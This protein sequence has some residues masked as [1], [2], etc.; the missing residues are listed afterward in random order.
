[1]KA[2]IEL[3]WESHKFLYR[4]NKIPQCQFPHQFSMNELKH[5]FC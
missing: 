1:M 5:V 4:F 3:L 2:E